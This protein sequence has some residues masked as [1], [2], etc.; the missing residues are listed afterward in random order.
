MVYLI[1]FPRCSFCS[2]IYKFVVTNTFSCHGT[3][4]FISSPE[5]VTNPKVDKKSM[6]KKY[7]VLMFSLLGM[8]RLLENLIFESLSFLTLLLDLQQTIFIFFCQLDWVI[9]MFRHDT[10]TFSLNKFNGLGQDSGQ[11][12][13]SFFG[14]LPN[15]SL[16]N[17]D[18]ENKESSDH[19]QST[20]NSKCQLKITKVFLM[21][22]V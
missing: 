22:N 8:L 5:T 12:G 13:M 11:S 4:A 1:G 7:P 19:V 2:V 3:I 16:A 14:H 17:K 9:N 15:W 18:E 10:K 21:F 20:Q 6:N